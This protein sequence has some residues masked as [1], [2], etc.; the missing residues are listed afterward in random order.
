MMSPE[1]RDARRQAVLGIAILDIALAL[2]THDA[3]GEVRHAW[4]RWRT[5]DRRHGFIVAG[6]PAN[7]RQIEPR[8]LRAAVI[9]EAT[10]VRVE[11]KHSCGGCSVG[12]SGS[13]G[14][15]VV[16]LGTTVHT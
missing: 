13:E 10:D 12:V 1:H 6:R 7:L 5:H 9:A 2:S 15:R 4:R 16:T 8:V 11:S 14:V 3:V